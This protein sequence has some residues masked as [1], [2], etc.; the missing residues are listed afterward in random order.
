MTGPRADWKEGEDQTQVE[1]NGPVSLDLT[2]RKDG[3]W[4]EQCL[5]GWQEVG[6][7]LHALRS[8]RQGIFEK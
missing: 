5:I 4:T 8:R 1:M 3:V 2:V 6:E 7:G